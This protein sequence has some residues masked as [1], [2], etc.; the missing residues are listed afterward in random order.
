MKQ[1]KTHEKAQGVLFLGAGGVSMASLALMA[2]E[3]GLRTYASDR[4]EN[5]MQPLRIKGIITVSEEDLATLSDCDALVYS[6]AVD[7]NH[8]QLR[9]AKEL[10]V[11]TYARPQW[12]GREMKDYHTRI[13]VAG[14]H[15]KST[16][17]AMLGKI[18]ESAQTDPCVLC[19]AQ[20]TDFSKSTCRLSDARQWMIAECCEYRD[21]FLSFPITQALLLNLEWDHVDYFSSLDQLISS[22]RDFAKRAQTVL[23][24]AED[25][26]LQK[27]LAPIKDSVK[28]ATF[29]VEVKADYTAT[30]LQ[31]SA[32]ESAFTFC[33][34]NVP[35]CEIRLQHSG[36]YQIANALAA[37][38]M[39]HQNG[40]PPAL[41]V[42]ALW[43]FQ[44]I[45]RRFE[46][47]GCIN[48]AQVYRDY[49][50]HPTELKA[51]FARARLLI[52]EKGRLIC[53]FQS[54]TYSRSAI[55]HSDF[56]QALSLADSVI[57]LPIF[58]AREENSYGASESALAEALGARFCQS[59]QEARDLLVQTAKKEDVILLAGAGDFCGLPELLTR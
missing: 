40:I 33:F 8:P 16:T 42:K 31:Q 6:L 41:I 30:N 10:G 12:L 45:A 46:E 14:T 2:K 19:G 39:A 57:L 58:S 38:S 36:R 13:G 29:A 7:E 26:N 20:M 1:S 48:G 51:V 35:L 23:Y 4:N 49:A 55:L 53:V 18:F 44:G 34:R 17:T 32:N 25:E 56:V 24:N 15:G 37:A 22:F 5:A 54:H 11:P 47:I 9:Y 50:H 21:A 3:K 28:S 52:E 59:A 43:E 27:A